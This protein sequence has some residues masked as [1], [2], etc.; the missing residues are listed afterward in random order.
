MRIEPVIKVLGVAII[1]FTLVTGFLFSELW[2]VQTILWL[3][4]GFIIYKSQTK[5]LPVKYKFYFQYIILTYL[6]V[7]SLL[8]TVIYYSTT[9][10]LL[11]NS[12]EHIMWSL[13]FAALIYYPLFTALKGTNLILKIFVLISVV[14]LIGVANELAEYLLRTAIQLVHIAYYADTIRDISLNIVG[15]LFFSAIIFFKRPRSE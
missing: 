13:F 11:L 8:K 4:L 9:G 7:E 12:L 14:N 6:L 2:V 1:I 10:F 3:I 15:T 5:H